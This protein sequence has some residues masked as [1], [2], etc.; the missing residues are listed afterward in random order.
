M[1][2]DI[3]QT[4]HPLGKQNKPVTKPNYDLFKGAI[5]AAVRSRP[6]THTQLVDDVTKRVSGKFDGNVSWHTMTVKLDL[7]ARRVIERTSSKPQTY[8]LV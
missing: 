5:V 6:L 3:V 4:K 1:A 2:A 7:E 8:R